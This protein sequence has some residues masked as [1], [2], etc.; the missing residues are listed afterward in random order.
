[1]IRTLDA[2]RGIDAVVTALERS[3]ETVAPE[4]HRT[5][6]EIL[7]AVRGRGDAALCA[8]TARLDGWSPAA[9]G[10]L[11]LTAA[12]FETAE[13]GIAPDVRAALEYAAVVNADTLQPINELTGSV[14]VAA[15][16][17]F[18]ATR[19]IDNALMEIPA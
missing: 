5:V 7:G 1:M 11:A 12:D 15:A 13:R 4:I 17:R 6:D 8:Y 9:A 18:G 10:E 16:V 14:L 3:P 2:R 19:L